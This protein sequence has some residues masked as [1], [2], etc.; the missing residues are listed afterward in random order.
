MPESFIDQMQEFSRRTGKPFPDP[1]RIEGFGDGQ[2][3]PP[4]TPE[5]PGEP[6]RVHIP[7]AAELFGGEPVEPAETPEP[8]HSAPAPPTFVPPI[9]AEDLVVVDRDVRFKGHRVTLTDREHGA[10]TALVLRALKRMVSEQYAEVRKLFPQ[11]QR[12]AVKAKRGRPK[13]EPA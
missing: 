4:P 6:T 2:P 3:P 1:T 8:S 9:P 13:K 11:R 5:T 7:T 12:R 10:L